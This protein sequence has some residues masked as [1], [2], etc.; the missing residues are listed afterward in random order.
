MKT[1]YIDASMGAAGDML[2]AALL[3]TMDEGAR[4]SFVAKL[5]ALGLPGIVYSLV[6]A[7]KC[8]ITGSHMDVTF[9]GEE[10][11]EEHHHDHDHEHEHHDHDHHEHHHHHSSMHDIEHIVTSHLPLSDKVKK[12]VMDVYKLIAEAES[13][14]HGKTVEEIHFHEVGTMDAIADVTAVCMLFDE[15]GANEVIV[16]PIHVGSGT[17]KCAHGILPVP[18]PATAFILKDCPIYSQDIK[19]ELCTPTGAALLKHFATSFGSMPVMSVSAI[20]YGMGK[21]DF[22][23]ANCVRVLV[24]EKEGSS[25]SVLELECNLDDMTPEAVGFAQ[26][27][28]LRDGALDVFTIPIGMKKSRPGILLSVICRPEDKGRMVQSIF[29]YTTTLGIRE[30]LCPRY[31]LSRKVSERDTEFGK[32]R[33]KE[34]FGYGVERSKLEYDDLAAIAR[35]KGL[36][37][38]E[39]KSRI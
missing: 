7:E 11:G 10:E 27:A 35:E 13:N 28:L 16:S 38:E 39:V 24:G 26:E 21:K 18:A 3:D 17:V 8:G 1:V 29:K 30:K 12:D 2:T 4:A 14:V 33:V 36:S 19:G 23:R 5:N 34:S 32:V 25:D 22:E 31:V 20:G 6:K 15:I 37:L 9:N